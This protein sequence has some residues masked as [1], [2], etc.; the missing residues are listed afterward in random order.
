MI[1]LL[2]TLNKYIQDDSEEKHK[3]L[4]LPLYHTTDLNTFKYK[5]LPD[6]KLRSIT[7]CSYNG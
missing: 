6:G 1:N 5:I 7:P 2:E 4:T 3:E